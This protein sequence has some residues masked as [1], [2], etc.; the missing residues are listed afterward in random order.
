MR[1]IRSWGFNYFT[2]QAA[3]PQQIRK[4]KKVSK[5]EI[6]IFEIVY[7]VSELPALTRTDRH[8]KIDSASDPDYEYVRDCYE[9][10]YLIIICR[11]LR[12]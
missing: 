11:S 3:S 7:I 1:T 12:A 9:I 5:P 10:L 6:P 4:K 8:A 2:D